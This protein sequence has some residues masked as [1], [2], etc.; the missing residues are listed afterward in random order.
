MPKLDE[1][2]EPVHAVV[3][4]ARAEEGVRKAFLADVRHAVMTCLECDLPLVRVSAGVDCDHVRVAFQSDNGAWTSGTF[5]WY[6]GTV[7]PSLAERMV[8]A[9]SNAVAA[10]RCNYERVRALLTPWL[11]APSLVNGVLEWK[12]NEVEIRLT[13]G[14]I[15][16]RGQVM[17]CVCSSGGDLVVLSPWGHRTHV[18]LQ[19]MV[20]VAH[21][22]NAVRMS[23]R[24][25]QLAAQKTP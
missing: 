7:G 19:E 2:L 4:L 17:L 12:R 16:E 20:N 15:G 24:R 3:N 1:L 5:A 13:G 23:D 8:E 22:V 25:A 11:G 18:G 21:A 6:A 9:G 10:T 14:S